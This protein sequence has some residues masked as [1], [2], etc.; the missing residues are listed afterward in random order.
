M[1]TPGLPPLTP[2]QQQALNRE[3]GPGER[4]LWSAQPRGKRMLT[5]FG[6][7]LF[8]IPWTVF[9]LF[10]EAMAFLPWFAGK[11]A[12]DTVTWGFGV[13]FPLFGLPFILVGLWMLWQPVSTVLAARRTVYALTS[14]RLI[15][16]EHGRTRRIESVPADR[17]GPIERTEGHDGWGR[18]S[19]QTHSLIDS[20][21]DRVTKSFDI[22]GV[23]AVAELERRLLALQ[24]QR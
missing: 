20:D 9:A 2:V 6:L 16:L 14:S 4:V 7:W 11:E 17:I 8:A 18:L 19:V 5:A 12:P 13:L 15:K 1:M 10:W 3:L 23:P 21:G 22:V 24:Q